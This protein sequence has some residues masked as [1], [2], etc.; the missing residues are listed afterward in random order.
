MELTPKQQ[1]IELI[2]SATRILL[3]THV[4]P[5]GDGI[6]SV[7]A[8]GGA[9]QKLGKTVTIA[10]SGDIPG[11]LKFLTGIDSVD[12][13]FAATKNLVITLS[14]KHATVEKLGYKKDPV[15]NEL[16]IIVTP[17]ESGEF[18]A[19]DVRIEAGAVRYDLIVVCDTP[20][21]DRLG[22]LYDDNT[23]LFY[24]TPV[25]NIDHHPGNDY[26]GKVNWIDLTA[27]S[28]AEILVSLIESL[29]REQPLLD[30]EI[31]T[32]L[33]TG[34]VFD[35]NSFQNA[36]TTPK[37]FT[38]AAQLVAAGARQQEIIKHLF[39]TKQLS[40]LRLWGSILARIHDESEQRFVWSTATEADFAK[41]GAAATETSGVVDE[42]LKTVPNIDFAFLLAERKGGVYGSFRGTEH[43]KNVSEIAALFGGG[44]HELAAAFNLPNTTLA[45]EQ[46]QIL[47]KVRDWQAKHTAA[48]AAG[49]SGSKN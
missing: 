34:I 9:L 37:S 43:G 38:V 8:L 21:V 23:Q 18:T 15:A 10:C 11:T 16:R 25:I 49:E 5:D 28:A 41:F 1:T 46:D 48:P 40:T 24:E 45:K 17:K 32:A 47:A 4:N 27:T 2:K 7:L 44:G 12:T 6:G 29:A 31:A 42:L 20:V 36:N 30:A 22:P 13:Q 19:D 14:T 35:T 33:L 26:F 3:V 39:K